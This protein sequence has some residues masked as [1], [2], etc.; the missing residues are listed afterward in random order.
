M[1]SSMILAGDVG[2]S[3]TRLALFERGEERPRAVF[4]RSYSDASF[5]DF[6]ALLA[7]FLGEARGAC[8]AARIERACLGV[9]GP[10]E[11]GR[12]RLTNRAWTVDAGAVA[13]ALGGAELILL[14]DFEAAA[15]G[16]DFLDSA[17]QQLLQ[18]GVPRRRA[19]QLVIG[20]GT[21]LGVAYRI[22]CGE[23]YQVLAGEG[24]HIGFAPVDEEQEGLARWLFA[25][26]GRVFAEQVVSGP[27]L[28][29][30]YR[31]LRAA[32]DPLPAG[33]ADPAAI[34]SRALEARDPLAR[35][36]LE[37][38]L[39]CFG[40]VAGDHALAV[41]AAGGVY[42]AGGI[43]RR[44]VPQLGASGFLSAFNSK[45]VHAPMAREFPVRVV[46]TDRLGLLGAAAFA[47]SPPGGSLDVR[48]I[49]TG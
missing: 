21:G 9:A 28:S 7:R 16:V 19:A 42:V 22:W 38:F 1:D 30:I 29:R 33:E 5:S 37:L 27:G 49:D 12:V 23:R 17:E 39:A 35:R 8:A 41:R 46:L 40:A 13:A 11:P 4:E 43:A 48:Q 18:A 10:V 14:N 34:C 44:I 45:G 47:V 6:E 2:G 31:Y 15:H 32:A 26:R 24:G 3:T 25:Q 20:A 36:A